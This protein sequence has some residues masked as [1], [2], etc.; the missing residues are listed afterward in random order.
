MC[1]KMSYNKEQVCEHCF[2]C[3]GSKKQNGMI[4]LKVE[5]CCY[6]V[7]KTNSR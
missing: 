3:P 2:G 7:S 6:R 1:A 5:D 4:A